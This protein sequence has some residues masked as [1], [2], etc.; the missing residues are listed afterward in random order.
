MSETVVPFVFV[1]DS[2]NREFHEDK[3]V[4]KLAAKQIVRQFLREELWEENHAPASW[5][6]SDLQNAKL[7]Q[8]AQAAVDAATDSEGKA[9]V[10]AES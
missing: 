3:P 5:E 7:D 4:S 2:I 8:K 6:P 10:W 9:I 1:C